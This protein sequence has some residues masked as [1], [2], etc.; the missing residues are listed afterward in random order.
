MQDYRLVDD[1]F[2]LNQIRPLIN[3]YYNQVVKLVITCR[4]I[5][6]NILWEEKQTLPY[7]ATMEWSNKLF[8]GLPTPWDSDTSSEK[9]ST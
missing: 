5:P 6:S 1:F 8:T 3:N 4:S 2:K 9:S 7:P